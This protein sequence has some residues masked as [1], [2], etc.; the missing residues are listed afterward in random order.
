MLLEPGAGSATGESYVPKEV[1]LTL[2]NSDTSVLCRPYCCWR[3]LARRECQSVIAARADCVDACCLIGA[4]D[5]WFYQEGRGYRSLPEMV[6]IYHDSVGHG[7]NMLLNI[8]PPPNSTMPQEAMDIYAALGR[9]IR[10]CYGE[11]SLPS[12]SALASTTTFGASNTTSVALTFRGGAATFDRFL[13]KEE[14][15]EGQNVLSFVVLADGQSIF[16]GTAIGRTLI[17]LL[18]T[19][20]TASKVRISDCD[21][22]TLHTNLKSGPGRAQGALREEDAVLPTVCRARPVVLLSARRRPQRLR[23]HRGH[24]VPRPTLFHNDNG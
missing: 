14:L 5:R 8:A 12:A 21:Q 7:G 16:N 4:P 18:P 10:S 13:I 11:G 20:V 6:S 24:G 15:R 9:F 1:D 2:Q 19:N 23:P 22:S 3:A 17:V